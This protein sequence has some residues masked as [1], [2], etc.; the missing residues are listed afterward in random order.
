MNTN[1][2]IEK[3]LSW[4]PCKD[5]TPARL[6]E[7]AAGRESITMLEA[8]SLPIPANDKLWLACRKGALSEPVRLEWIERTL[9]QAVQSYTLNCGVPDI[10]DWSRKW[11]AG[12]EVA[13]S[14]VGAMTAYR[15]AKATGT[16]SIQE[17]I[18]AVILSVSS[19]PPKKN[20]TEQIFLS[21][22]EARWFSKAPLIGWQARRDAE[23]K[24][25]DQQIA[26]LAKVLGEADS[27]PPAADADPN[28]HNWTQCRCE[29]CKEAFAIYLNG[30][31]KLS[32][33]P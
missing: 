26:D 33:K 5:Y 31:R 19:L 12:D 4:G 29:S 14:L 9:R 10:E 7:L 2:T 16:L 17:P 32:D 8:L 24:A 20:A 27:L 13:R 30:A 21:I 25:Y 1:I 28:K 22:D 6:L 23:E 3:V 15:T 11:L 18:W